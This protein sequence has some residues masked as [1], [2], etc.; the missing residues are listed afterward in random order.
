[1]KS[2]V[3]V[4]ESRGM[5]VYVPKIDPE[6]GKKI[7]ILNDYGHPK[8]G[9]FEEHVVTFQKCKELKHGPNGEYYVLSKFC[10]DDTTAPE[11]AKRMEEKVKE[12]HI[13]REE[14][15]IA[16]TNTEQHKALKKIE[17]ME[18]DNK[19]KDDI[20]AQLEAQVAALKDGGQHDEPR[21]PGRPKREG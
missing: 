12:G 13:E 1:M 16:R 2:K 4:V 10:V 21:R 11:I 18:S 14:D 8:P 15:Y 6:T 9:E 5:R 20:I 19:A 17:A 7:P 3:Y